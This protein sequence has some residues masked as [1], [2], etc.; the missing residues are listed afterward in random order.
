M[1]EKNDDMT[2]KWRKIGESDAFKDVKYY[3]KRAMKNKSIM[4]KLAYKHR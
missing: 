1:D 3:N 4:N 2:I